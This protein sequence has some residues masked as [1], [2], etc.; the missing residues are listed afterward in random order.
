M[1]Q[2]KVDVVRGG[3]VKGAWKDGYEARMEKKEI[4]LVEVVCS[5]GHKQEVEE[6][7]K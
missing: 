6:K 3:R 4:G 7:S 1:A 5:P 2:V